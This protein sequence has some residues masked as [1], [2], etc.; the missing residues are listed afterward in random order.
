MA[1]VYLATERFLAE[2]EM[3]AKLQHPGT[4]KC[5]WRVARAWLARAIEG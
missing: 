3:T 1:T 5:D 4:V 2:I